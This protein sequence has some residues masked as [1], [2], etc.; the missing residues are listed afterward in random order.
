MNSPSPHHRTEGPDSR[1]GQVLANMRKQYG[2]VGKSQAL[3]VALLVA[4]AAIS[5]DCLL[6]L[7]TAVRW[8]AWLGIAAIAVLLVWHWKRRGKQ[9]DKE[10]VVIAV[11]QKFPE[12]GQLPRTA[13]DIEAGKLGV[14]DGVS[15]HMAS[16]V[17]AR[18]ERF[19]AKVDPEAGVDPSLT[20][21]WI[22]FAAMAVALVSILFISWGDFRVATA[23]LL[24]PSSGLTFTRLDEQTVS[25]SYRSAD[26]FQFQ[27]KVTGRI[28]EE[29]RLRWRFREGGPKEQV[30]EKGEDGLYEFSTRM[31]PG[32]F[33]YSL[34][35]GDA[36]LPWKKVECVDAALLLA[37]EGKV[38]PPSYTGR[39]VQEFE[40]ADVEGLE[41]SLVELTF[42]M[43]LPMKSARLVFED[44][45]E[46]EAQIEGRRILISTEIVAGKRVYD[47]IGLDE[48]D[49]AIETTKFLM[50]GNPDELPQIE[51]IEPKKEVAATPVGEVPVRIRARDDIGLGEVG[52]VLETQGEQRE[53]LNL[54]I[55]ED[56]SIEIKELVHAALEQFSLSIND[57]VRLFAYAKDK[58]PRGDVRAVSEM[59]AIDIQQFQTRWFFNEPGAGI[60]IAAEVLEGAE[61]HVMVERRI[62]SQ[63]FQEH[64]AM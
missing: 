41:G 2:R 46:L 23:R 30:L 32:G 44:D 33:E 6:G 5:L 38:T 31:E 10:E 19:W 15:A 8:L 20:K 40:T 12:V 13:Q 24:W 56:G 22:S 42:E 11:E 60:P 35:G 9:I 59:R 3:F 27:I 61:D 7:A 51:I 47:L 39:G 58:K 4:V 64:E 17:R 55:G 53:L 29:V 36:Q 28:P 37:S 14:G 49:R 57:N 52:V 43:T 45:Q 48:N 54:P 34:V 62:V 25:E 26:E 16:D 18:S 63:S 1:L 50:D 21:K